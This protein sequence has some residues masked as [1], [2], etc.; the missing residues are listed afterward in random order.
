MQRRHWLA[1]GAMAGFLMSGCARGDAAV[2]A[3]VDS[4]LAADDSVGAIRLRVDTKDG[5][6]TLSGTVP[7]QAM[8]LRALA[9]ARQTNGI[10]DVIDRIVVQPV[11][12]SDSAGLG[13]AMPG[14]MPGRPRQGHM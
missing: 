3:R 5:I 7:G 8:R 10:T 12:P 6:V 4:A 2:N 13:V 14:G 1:Y 9:V 11:S